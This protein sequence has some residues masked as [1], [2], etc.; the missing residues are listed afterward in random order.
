MIKNI[1]LDV[2]DVLLEYRWKD[3]LMDHGLCEEDAVRVGQE[4]FESPLWGKGLDLGIMPQEEVIAQFRAEFPEDGDAIEWFIKNGEQM[5]VAR[6]EIW[7]CVRHLKE[8]GYG[9]YLL[10]NY[11]ENLFQKH[12]KD[13]D[14]MKVAD[15][16]V[17]SYQVHLIKPDPRIYQCLLERYGLKP[18]ECIFFDDRK[19]NVEG[20]LAVG[21]RAIQVTSREML[22][23][24]LKNFECNFAK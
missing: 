12:T 10:S 6:P 24:T 17:V 16:M 7:E 1:I 11:S 4:I 23:E 21:I 9:I 18:E 8:Q 5:H 20:A 13:V 19:E 22:Y 2:G 15:G 3:M 14:F